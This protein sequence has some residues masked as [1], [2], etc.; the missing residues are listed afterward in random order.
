MKVYELT[1]EEVTALI[2]GLHYLSINDTDFEFK[3]IIKDLLLKLDTGRL[4]VGGKI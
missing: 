2:T 3:D 1:D 4:F